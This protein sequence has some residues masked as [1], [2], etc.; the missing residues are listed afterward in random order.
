MAYE[1][2]AA[3]QLAVA[4]ATIANEGRMM[5]PYVVSKILDEDGGTI[6]ENSPNFIRQ[7]IRPKTA[8]TIAA[9]LEG[10]VEFGTGGNAKIDGYRIAGKTGTA[11]KPDL[12]DGGY[13]RDKYV[14]VFAGF[15]PVDDPA[16]AI[17]VVV[18]SPHEEHYGGIVS[19]PAFHESIL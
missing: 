17:V 13:Y 9:M 15:V 2:P 4:F 5:Q 18:D 1:V 14:A 6:T 3:I 8:G 11:Q 12:V 16:A 10:V 19:A 7:V